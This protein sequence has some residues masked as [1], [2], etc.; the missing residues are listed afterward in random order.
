MKRYLKAILILVI[1][2]FV[3]FCAYY[4]FLLSQFSNLRAYY[5][6]LKIISDD[7]KYELVIREW[8][9]FQARGAEIYCVKDAEMV[10]LGG[11]LTYDVPVFYNGDYRVQWTDEYV[12]IKYR[13]YR[14][15]EA[16]D[17]D[18]WAVSEFLLP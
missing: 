16:N 3:I 5:E 11:T 15:E 14:G 13:L 4:L 2:A 17:P 9:C 12:I 6:D 18:T 1:I 10:E 8:T 7:G